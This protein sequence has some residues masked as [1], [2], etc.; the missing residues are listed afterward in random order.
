M[1]II[2]ITT[3]YM[4]KNVSFRTVQLECA[5]RSATPQIKVYSKDFPVQTVV[6]SSSPQTLYLLI[7]TAV[8]L[9][10]ITHTHTVG[11]GRRGRK[12]ET[13]A[14]KTSTTNKIVD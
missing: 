1:S 11:R 7:F 12:R 5:H 14:I 10:L 3:E 13:E 8:N 4:H 2:K 6:Y 9:I